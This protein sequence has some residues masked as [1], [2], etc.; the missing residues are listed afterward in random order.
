MQNNFK[1]KYRY[2]DPNLPDFFVKNGYVIIK[3]LFDNK[4]IKELLN[5]CKNKIFQL[6]K[7]HKNKKIKKDYELWSFVIIEALEKSE[8]YRSYINSPKLLSILHKFLGPDVCTLGYNSLW[9]NNPSNNNPVINKTPHVDAWTGTSPNTLFFKVF[10]TDVD[11]FNGLTVYPGSNCQGM[12]PVKSRV[13]NSED[14]NLKFNSVNLNNIIKGDAVLWHALTLH[15]TTGQSDKNQ[16]ISMTARFSSTETEFSSQERALGYTALSVGPLNQ[17]KRL[18]G[19][20]Y[21]YPLRT[22]NTYVGTDKRLAQLYNQ[23][24]L[25]E[26]EKLKNLLK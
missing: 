20:D 23:K 3:G 24:R 22:Y 21:L 9:I 15:A 18:I 1:K 17:I 7:L 12:I 11:N 4:T 14:F 5:F 13:I 19:N 6:E 26:T 8:I 25:K 10:L 16:R 2:N